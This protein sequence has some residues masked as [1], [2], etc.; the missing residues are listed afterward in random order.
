MPLVLIL[1][2]LIAV[3]GGV[4]YVRNG[5]PEATP[6][7]APVAT[8]TRPATEETPT[9]TPEPEVVAAPTRDLTTEE[10]ATTAAADTYTADGSYL[11]PART[12]HKLSVTLTVADGIVT[13]ASVTYDDGEGFSNPNQERFDGAYK[14][15]VIGKPVTGIS[16][17]RV[18]GASL[19]TEAFNQAVS[20]IASQIP[21]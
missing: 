15:E 13:D 21:S 8:E 18:G 2:A 12:S 9:Q 11:T 19:T 1:I 4:I 14:A 6:T 17:S 5:N 16:L 20:D 10:A 3:V 7:P